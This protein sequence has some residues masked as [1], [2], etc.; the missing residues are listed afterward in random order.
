[1]ALAELAKSSRVG[2]V[3]E[4]TEIPVR[5]SV[6]GLCELLG[7]D[8]MYVACEGR[9]VAV[10]Q[11]IAA[12]AVLNA[13]LAHP[14]G[15]QSRMIGEVVAEHPNTVVMNTCVGGSRVVDVLSGEQLP[16]IC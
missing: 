7:L 16:R 2:M 13:M 9:L 4:E 3:L 15:V 8:P 14:L 1:M 6:A 10:V 11:E 5:E 12:E